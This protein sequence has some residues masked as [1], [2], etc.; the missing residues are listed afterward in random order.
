LN[1]QRVSNIQEYARNYRD[2]TGA[3]ADELARNA[4]K[5]RK[6]RSDL[7]ANYYERIKASLRQIC[8]RTVW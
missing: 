6:Q 2:M 4:L 1:D 7:L 5:Y 3:K 8:K